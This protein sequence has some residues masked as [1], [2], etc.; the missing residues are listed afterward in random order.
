[1]IPRISASLSPIARL[2]R[3]AVLAFL[4]LAVAFAIVAQP[5][6]MAAPEPEPIP[7]RWQLRVEP[8]DLRIATVETASGPRAY[9]YM[10]FKVINA[11]G[12]D[13]DFA[14]SFELATDTGTIRRSGR[15]V[16]REVTETLLSKIGSPLVTDETGVQ[17]RL[18]QGPENAREALVIWPADDLQAS[19][20]NVYLIGF[21]GETKAISRPDTGQSVIL[22]KTLML[23][24][25]GTG[26]LDP[27]SGRPLPRVQERW[28]LR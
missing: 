14:P 13:R 12:E 16:P 20:Y 25:E 9:L 8:G 27:T 24:H 21:S 6:V 3:R 17:G 1:M 7:R 4:A 23:R 10:T 5:T 28:I 26:R 15:D 18:L 19:E 2:P 11:S 22:R